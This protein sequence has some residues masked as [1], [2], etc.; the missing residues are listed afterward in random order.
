MSLA[1]HIIDDL[2][3]NGGRK[4]PAGWTYVIDAGESTVGIES[5]S[6]DVWATPG[7]D[8]D[9]DDVVLLDITRLG[10]DLLM[11]DDVL[12]AVDQSL[13]TATPAHWYALMCHLATHLDA[14]TLKAKPPVVWADGRSRT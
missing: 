12:R 10:T 2:R 3:A 8:G 11:T 14:D 5:A 13:P 1:S 9:P 7:Y 4:L 6:F